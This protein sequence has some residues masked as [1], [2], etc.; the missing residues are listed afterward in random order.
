[1]RKCVG[2]TTNV[3]HLQTVIRQ[4][5]STNVLLK[6]HLDKQTEEKK[7][8]RKKVA[9]MEKTQA[10]KDKFLAKKEAEMAD[11][12]KK[13][14]KLEEVKDTS[15]DRTDDII[16]SSQPVKSSSTPIMRSSFTTDDSD[17]QYLDEVGRFENSYLRKKGINDENNSPV[18]PFP[19]MAQK[20][21]NPFLKI[22]ESENE[23]TESI[24]EIPPYQPG[25]K[26]PTLSQVINTE[27][28]DDI[29]LV[30]PIEKI[31]K[32]NRLY[33]TSSFSVGQ[34]TKS[35]LNDSIEIKPLTKTSSSYI[36]DGLGGRQ[37]VLKTDNLKSYFMT[38]NNKNQKLSK[39]KVT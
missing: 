30:K 16:S 8:L 33:K 23:D 37:K 5:V 18:T 31:A 1:M 14:A 10:D 11:L 17:I 29:L 13:I 9:Q 27:S 6:E 2:S 24:T 39:F 35:K 22:S 20:R 19:A 21:K 25:P 28:S 4:L 3:S 12:L 34:T 15:I 7:L 38:T 32:P 36:F 26:K